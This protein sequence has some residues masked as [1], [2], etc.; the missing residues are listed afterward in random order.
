MSDRYVVRNPETAWR[1]Y[2][3]QAVILLAGDSTLNTLNAV[4]TYI[5][6]EADGTTPVSAIVARVCEEFEVEPAQAERDSADFIDKLCQ[7]G[8]LMVTESPQERR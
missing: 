2:D 6:R 4:G 7:R 1:V 5:W 8:L 3:G